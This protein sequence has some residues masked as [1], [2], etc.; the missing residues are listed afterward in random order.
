MTTNREQFEALAERIATIIVQPP[1]PILHNA[2]TIAARGI[3]AFR[4]ALEHPHPHQ[5]PRDHCRSDDAAGE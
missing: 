5:P 3:A 4:D 2:E 1:K